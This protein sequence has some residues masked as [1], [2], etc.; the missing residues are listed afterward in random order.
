M[1]TSPATNSRPSLMDYMTYMAD[2]GLSLDRFVEH[3]GRLVSHEDSSGLARGLA[4]LRSKI[5]TLRWQHPQLALQLEFLTNLFA[6]DAARD[7]EQVRT[8]PE[9]VRNETTFALLYAAREMDMMPDDI[10]DIGYLDDA[11]IVEMVLSR[12]DRFFE[13][14]CLTHDLDWAPL[15]PAQSP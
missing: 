13:H 6:K 2:E 12:H 4:D 1:L 14:Y 7:A 11:A 15:R 8:L 5:S 3:G 9:T 10:P